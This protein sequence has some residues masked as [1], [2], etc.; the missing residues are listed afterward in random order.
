MKIR[1]FVLLL[2]LGVLFASCEKLGL[3]KDGEFTFPREE[4]NSGLLK[5]SGY[6]YNISEEYPNSVKIILLNQNGVIIGSMGGSLEEVQ[7]E[8]IKLTVHENFKNWKSGWGIYRIKNGNIEIQ[9]WQ[10]IQSPC[11]PIKVE[12]GEI[13]NDST[14]KITSWQD[15]RKRKINEV[16]EIYEFKSYSPK[17]DSINSFIP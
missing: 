17:P 5:L 4:D 15:C 10:T 7:N 8:S 6:Y 9:S 2:S 13:L 16:E 14:F 3:C 11:K 1:T 12:K